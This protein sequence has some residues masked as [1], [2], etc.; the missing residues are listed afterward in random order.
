[1]DDENKG[2]DGSSGRAGQRPS[3]SVRDMKEIQKCGNQSQCGDQKA[4]FNVEAH[5]AEV[6]IG[7]LA[8]QRT[9]EADNHRR[10][11]DK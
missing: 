2:K 7:E 8:S 5:E 11:T 6:P 4:T 3:D 1:L 10:E 9:S